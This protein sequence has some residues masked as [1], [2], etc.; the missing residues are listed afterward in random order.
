VPVRARLS[1]LAQLAADLR[2]V[3]RE[4]AERGRLHAA[5]GTLAEVIQ[6]RVYRTG[7]ELMLRQRLVADDTAAGGRV[8][9]RPATAAD[10]AALAD[11]N[12]RL[13][14][15]RVTP[16]FERRLAVGRPALL[17]FVD[18]KL[19]GYFWW[20]D[21]AHASRKPELQHFGVRLARDDVYGHSFLV[22]PEHRGRDAAAFLAAV[23]AELA[24]LGYRH[25]Y[26]GVEASNR[27]ARWLYSIRG[28]E[29]V[30]RAR[31]RTVLG[32]LRVVDGRV[33]LVQGDDLRPLGRPLRRQAALPARPPGAGESGR[34]SGAP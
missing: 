21:P 3:H 20:L 19:I 22:A 7:E 23:E 12:R 10:L 2:G 4:H 16:V 34:G 24:R 31:T 28:Y 26:G 29:V 14:R 6:A 32:R 18:D 17:G 11:L 27:P 25:M 8:H 13:S 15:T 1:R 9:V 33:Y 30:A 5:R